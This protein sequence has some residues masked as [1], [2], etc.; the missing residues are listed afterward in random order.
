MILGGKLMKKNK[1]DVSDD[2]IENPNQ[3][4]VWHANNC[5]KDGDTH[6]PDMDMDTLFQFA[7]FQCA[8]LTFFLPL[9]LT[10]VHAD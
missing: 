2:W 7:L 8:V 5:L 3:L 1:I 10:A 6:R 4:N 9:W